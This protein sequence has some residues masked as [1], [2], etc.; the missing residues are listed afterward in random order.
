MFAIPSWRGIAFPSL[1]SLPSLK[2]PTLP[3]VSI[4]KPFVLNGWIELTSQFGLPG[5]RY[6]YQNNKLHHPT[7]PA[8]I[9]SDGTKQYWYEGEKLENEDEL[10]IR[11]IIQ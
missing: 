4:F 9:F 11:N 8:I 5:D 1:P 6:H 2:L 7:G 3:L 10:T